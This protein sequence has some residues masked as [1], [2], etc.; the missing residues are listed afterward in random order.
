[1]GC[2]KL[3]IR[4]KIFSF[5]FLCRRVRNISVTILHCVPT[6]HAGKNGSTFSTDILCLTAQDFSKIKNINLKIRIAILYTP[7]FGFTMTAQ[8]DISTGHP[9]RPNFMLL[10]FH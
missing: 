4:T 3:N 2:K 6:A 10:S 1:V 9:V 5:C 8:A 7:L